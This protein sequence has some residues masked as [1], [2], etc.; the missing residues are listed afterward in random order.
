MKK[1]LIILGAGGHARA[2][3]SLIL[4]C[5]NSF[6][7]V[8]DPQLFSKGI[9]VWEGLPVLGGDIFLDSISPI[10]Y[11]LVNGIGYLPG[12]QDRKALYKKMK[13]KGFLFPALVHPFSW[14]SPDTTLSDGVQIMAGVVIQPHCII[15]CNSIVNTR[16]SI[17]HDCEIGANVHISPG[18]TICGGVIVRDDV[19]VGA[20]STVIQGKEL[21]EGSL[22]AAGATCIKSLEDSQKFIT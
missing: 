1:K 13:H 21:G 22:V 14:I 8:C 18:A 20:G 16:A 10:E 9:D 15:G 2:L 6:V 7:G 3:N 12:S 19:F 5:K 11:S 4:A 17:D